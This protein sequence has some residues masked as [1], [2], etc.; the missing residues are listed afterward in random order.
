[1]IRKR[2]AMRERGRALASEAKTSAGILAVLPIISGLGLWALNPDY[3]S[4][5]FTDT[6][7]QFVLAG[8]VLMLFG[9][10]MSMRMIIKKSLQ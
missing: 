1:M 8:A 10:I 3:M 2:V 7:G 4:V 6:T 5:L 9:G